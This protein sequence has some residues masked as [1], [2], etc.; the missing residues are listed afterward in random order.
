LET[1]RDEIATRLPGEKLES[2]NELAVR[3]KTSALT[4][5]EALSALAEEGLIERRRGSGTYVAD[6]K[7][8]QH[9]GVLI[10]LDISH[11]RASF[12]YRRVTQQLRLLF[13][14]RGYRE[15]LYAGHSAPGGAWNGELSC[16][17]FLEDLERGLLC[18]LAAIATDARG[19]WI[20]AVRERGIPVVGSGNGYEYSITIDMNRLICTG[21]DYLLAQGRR[22]VAYMAWG[23]ADGFLRASRDRGVQVRPEWVRHSLHPSAQGAGWE[24]LREIWASSERKPDGLLIADDMLFSDARAAVAD[25]GIRVPE[26]L[27]IVSHANRGM[28]FPASFP[29]TRIEVDPDACAQAMGTVLV[30]LLEGRAPAAKKMEAPFW[31]VPPEESAP[32]AVTEELS[33]ETD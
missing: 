3:F 12:F 10:E 24:E 28:W 5:R 29:V 32:D 17:E 11:P 31:I 4:V 2:Q 26:D 13:R 1:L 9:V 33:M 21:L 8:R 25:L 22:R 15:Q 20:K 19:P 7:E 14:E 16:G 18:G 23:S 30:D 6:R 27:M